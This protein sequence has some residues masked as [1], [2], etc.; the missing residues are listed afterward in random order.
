MLSHFSESGE[1]HRPRRMG[2]G[3]L[4]HP[5]LP[6]H[7]YS[8]HTTSPGLGEPLKKVLT[9]RVGARDA[10]QCSTCWGPGSHMPRQPLP[11]LW[12]L[13]TACQRGEKKRY[14]PR[15]HL[16]KNVILVI[17]IAP[18]CGR[19]TAALTPTHIGDRNSKMSPALNARQ[20]SDLRL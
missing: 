8:L 15:V 5:S 14:F 20:Y 12:P 16:A 17:C 2:R 7:V 6:T 1:V 13:E 3:L 18:L 9:R 11:G 4:L 10:Y 19:V